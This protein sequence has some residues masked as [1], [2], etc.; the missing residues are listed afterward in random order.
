MAKWMTVLTHTH[1]YPDQ[2][3]VNEAKCKEEL[4]ADDGESG[5]KENTVSGVAEDRT[6][7][8]EEELEEDDDEEEEREDEEAEDDGERSPKRVKTDHMKL[9]SPAFYF[10][11]H[12][13][14]PKGYCCVRITELLTSAPVTTITNAT[15]ATSP[16]NEV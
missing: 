7:R 13:H 16:T 4:G 5:D 6:A 12:R 14:S 8:V 3:I 2:T 9:R 10:N 11:L 1:T 15:A